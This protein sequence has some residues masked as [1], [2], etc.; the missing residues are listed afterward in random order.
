MFCVVA[1]HN[2]TNELYL[3]ALQAVTTANHICI[4]FISDETSENTKELMS[5][6][7]NSGIRVKQIMSDEEIVDILSQEL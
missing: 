4:L 7:R 6:M 5:S 3:A 1:T 2:L